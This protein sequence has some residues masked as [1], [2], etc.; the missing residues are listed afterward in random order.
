MFRYHHPI[1]YQTSKRFRTSWNSN[2]PS[3]LISL[4]WNS[5]LSNS[6][7]LLLATTFP[8]RR[9]FLWSTLHWKWPHLITKIGGIWFRVWGEKIIWKLILK[10]GYLEVCILECHLNMWKYFFVN[11][12]HRVLGYESTPEHKKE[13]AAEYQFLSEH[14][15]FLIVS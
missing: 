9:S 12:D 11:Q 5:S 4:V 3:E 15:C 8:K 14:L 13:N 2:L 7:C 10:T 1:L 6:I